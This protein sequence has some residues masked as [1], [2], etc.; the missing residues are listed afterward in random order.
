M[1]DPVV[2]VIMSVYN[3]PLQWVD[4][5]IKSILNQTFSDIEFIIINDN[6]LSEDLDN[7]LNLYA[8]KDSRIKIIKNRENIGLTKSLN[9]GLSHANGKYIARMDADDISHKDRFRKQVNFLDSNPDV[10]VCGTKIKLFGSRMPFFCHTIFESDE[11]I[12]G[13]ML[14]NS[15][16]AH[17]TVMI[18]RS[19][20]TE[21]N[22]RYDENFKTSQDYKLWWDLK[23]YGKYANIP[24]VLLNYRVSKSQISKIYSQ[25]QQG[26][27]SDISSL[28]RNSWIY[29]LRTPDSLK[30]ERDLILT[31]NIRKYLSTPYDKKMYAYFLRALQYQVFSFN[32]MI[33]C[34][35]STSTKISVKERFIIA[36]LTLK[37]LLFKD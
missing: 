28:F 3:E 34:C 2:S 16:F 18:R 36:A 6:P 7:F 15:G 32:N 11:D 27:K 26:C 35:F 21:N 13:Q 29:H 33:K 5:A 1:K 23:D 10:T 25:Q 14:L 20:L 22:I 4:S 9:I 17:P 12:R 30:N 8:E 24:E 31:K 19:V 37:H